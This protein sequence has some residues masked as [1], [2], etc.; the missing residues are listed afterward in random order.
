MAN[1]NNQF[2]MRD[3]FMNPKLSNVFPQFDR[4][5]VNGGTLTDTD[6]E[7]KVKSYLVAALNAT[8][9]GQ[10]ELTVNGTYDA[11]LR[12]VQRL[13]ALIEGIFNNIPTV[14]QSM[15]KN[16]RLYLPYATLQQIADVKS[17][18]GKSKAMQAVIDNL[19]Y[20]GDFNAL[21][22]VKYEKTE[23]FRRNQRA[24]EKRVGYRRLKKV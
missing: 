6:I 20:N 8:V 21:N 17:I 2:G 12:R 7:S 22:S 11:V 13:Q 5:T 14:M 10:N 4:N 23:E 19:Q 1:Y 16:T 9:T 15:Q 18:D 24:W 3:L